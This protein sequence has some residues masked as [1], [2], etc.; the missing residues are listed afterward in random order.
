MSVIKLNDQNFSEEVL[1]YKGVCVVDFYADWCGPCKIMEPILDEVAKEEKEVKFGKLDVDG[2]RETASK[3]RIMSIP[4][5]LIFKDGELKKQL[6]GVQE[7][8]DLIKEAK[9]V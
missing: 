4:T 2:S 3:F 5:I 7:K 1:D 8:E 9:S 6:S